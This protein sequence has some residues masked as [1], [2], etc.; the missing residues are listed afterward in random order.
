M[1]KLAVLFCGLML[2]NCATKDIEVP[3]YPPKDKE[4]FLNIVFH[5]G[6]KTKLVWI[7][8]ITHKKV[9][10]SIDENLTDGINAYTHYD[11]NGKV[12]G[13]KYFDTTEL[14]EM[15]ITDLNKFKNCKR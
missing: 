15:K 3:V 10:E 14:I 6:N 8:K 2:C 9:L 11:E 4:A 7:D 13:V 5:C 12:C 1:K